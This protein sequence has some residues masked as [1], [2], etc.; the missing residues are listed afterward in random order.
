MLSAFILMR[1]ESIVTYSTS[2]IVD[3]ST[4][5]IMWPC[6]RYMHS[7]IKMPCSCKQ[8]RYATM[9]TFNGLT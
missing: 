2:F 7:A 1:S 4:T 8:Q 9:I 3:M 6:D 5:A